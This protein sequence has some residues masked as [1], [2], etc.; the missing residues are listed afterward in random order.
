MHV[1]ERI[2]MDCDV[3]GKKEEIVLSPMTK[4]PTPIEKSKKASWQHKNA[5]KNFDYTDY[6]TIADQ[7]NNEASKH[8]LK[9]I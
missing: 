8:D 3:K 4:A 7:R 6:T 5:T 1:Y 2:I 9:L